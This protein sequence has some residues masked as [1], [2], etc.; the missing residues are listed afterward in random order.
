MGGERERP[1]GVRRL[2]TCLRAGQA[3]IREAWRHRI[4]S[5][6]R[7]PTDRLAAYELEDDIPLIERIATAL[8]E[9]ALW[10]D[11]A[12]A[13][14]ELAGLGP[15]A[16]RHVH[17]RMKEGYDLAQVLRELH[18]L[19]DAIVDTCE[20]ALVHVGGEGARVIHNA[21]DSAMLVAAESQ[22][23]ARQTT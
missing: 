7:V 10:R 17:V 14:G 19:R 1:D 22:P 20:A 11:D 21:I 18:H 23:R 5:D 16:F 13:R 2:A 15:P 4:T 8:D 9:Y 6:P 12:E 3:G